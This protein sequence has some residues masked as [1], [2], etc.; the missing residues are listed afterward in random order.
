[1]DFRRSRGSFEGPDYSK[2]AVER[3]IAEKYCFLRPL[4][5]IAVRNKIPLG[6]YVVT[7]YHESGLEINEYVAENELFSQMKEQDEPS[8]EMMVNYLYEYERSIAKPLPRTKDQM[9]AFQDDMNVVTNYIYQINNGIHQVLAKKVAYPLQLDVFFVAP[10]CH[11]K[12]VLLHLIITQ[13]RGIFILK[14]ADSHSLNLH[15]LSFGD[16]AMMKKSD[17]NSRRN[18]AVDA[19]SDVYNLIVRSA[20]QDPENLYRE[21]GQRLILLVVRRNVADSA[22]DTVYIFKPK[23]NGSI[24]PGPVSDHVD[25][26]YLLRTKSDI[27]PGLAWNAEGVL[28]LSHHLH[29]AESNKVYLSY[30]QHKSRVFKRSLLQRLSVLV[31]DGDGHPADS[32]REFKDHKYELLG[33][34]WFDN[35]RAYECYEPF[36]NTKNCRAKSN[37]FIPKRCTEHLLKYIDEKFESEGKLFYN[38]DYIIGMQIIDEQT[39]SIKLSD[40]RLL[41]LVNI[42]LHRNGKALYALIDRNTKSS[43][44]QVLFEGV[45]DHNS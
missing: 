5:Q 16:N 44:K 41:T 43:A 34:Y 10:R 2:I 39:V 35:G 32:Y 6:E 42:E 22:D 23:E 4:E 17:I 1:M 28:G 33:R 20:A 37:V 19:I 38:M 26:T 40:G 8:H 15:A 7:G 18:G 29:S 25:L 30:G 24:P 14:I 13:I 21:N 31:S 45:T 11:K 9:M 27:V 3:A 36:W 12:Y